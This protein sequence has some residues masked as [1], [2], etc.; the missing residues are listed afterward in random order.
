MRRL[1]RGG[2]HTGWSA[3]WALCLW[4]RLLDGGLAHAS[5]R[6]A[7]HDFLSDGLLG[8]HPKLSGAA[9]A[10]RGG[11]GG[12][13]R[14]TTCVGRVGG[15]GEGIFQLDAN[16]GLAAGVAELLLQSHTA[17]CHV[18]LLPALPPSWRDGDARGL[19][20]RNA[21]RVD[22]GWARGRLRAATIARAPPS[23]PG[24]RVVRAAGPV[25]VC[26]APRVCGTDAAPLTAAAR[27]SVRLLPEAPPPPLTAA[28]EA[29]AANA[30]T[31]QVWTWEI[32]LEDGPWSMRL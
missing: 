15:A 25:R 23:A 18:H 14:C 12:A 16:G 2:G 1:R 24:A 17:R 20:A 27:T 3:A 29:S 5:L 10:P 32:A 13:V 7:M 30:P 11:G 4:A 9:A 8:L 28:D 31:T 22:V 19:R 21:L 6:F 26:C